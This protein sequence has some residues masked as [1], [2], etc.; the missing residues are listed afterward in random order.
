MVIVCGGAID[1][2]AGVEHFVV[3]DLRRGQ[4]EHNLAGAVMYLDEVEAL[5][6]EVIVTVLKRPR[7]VVEGDEESLFVTDADHLVYALVSVDS[8]VIV[9]VGDEVAAG[10]RTV[11]G[12]ATVDAVTGQNYFAPSE[13]GNHLYVIKDRPNDFYRDAIDTVIVSE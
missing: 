13:D 8:V 3:H 2:F 12:K 9:L 7:G 10:Y 4:T 6:T 5:V 1:P 11:R